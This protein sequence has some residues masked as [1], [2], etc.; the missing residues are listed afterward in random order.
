MVVKWSH[1]EDSLFC[2]LIVQN[3]DNNAQPRDD[4]AH[5][6]KSGI[7]RVARKASDTGNRRARRE[8]AAIP[9]ENLCGVNVEKKERDERKRKDK[10]K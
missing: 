10:G 2:A 6:R 5:A 9:H 7:E 4:E 8:R 3:L 1:F